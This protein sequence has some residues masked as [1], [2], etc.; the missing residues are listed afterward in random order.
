MC[1]IKKKI[2]FEKSRRYRKLANKNRV[3]VSRSSYL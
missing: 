2:H 3:R 1:E